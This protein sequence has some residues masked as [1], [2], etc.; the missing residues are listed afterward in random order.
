[1]IGTAR[2][3][4]RPMRADDLAAFV[5]YR[6]DPAVA[7]YQSW[8]VSFDRA[9]AERFL[10]G[11]RRTAFGTPGEW[12]QL[13]IAGRDGGPLLGDCACCV[14]AEQP[15]T[16]EVGV[17]LARASQGRGVAAEALA[18]LLGSLFAAHGMHRVLAQAD[19]RNV[20]AHRLLERLGLRC[21]ARL[22]EADWSK[23][24]W[25]TLRVYAIL[26]REWRER[27]A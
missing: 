26:A 12:V 11:Q 18:A 23:G 25:T 21:E 27:E 16:A 7:R 17:T 19:D 2:L 3:V 15:R 13:A 22:V 8:D 14:S 10:A 24:E 5:A 9:E 1:V 20:A 6:R 4:L